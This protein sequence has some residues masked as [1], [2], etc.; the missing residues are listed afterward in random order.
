MAHIKMKL[1]IENFI[2]LVFIVILIS[3][4]RTVVILWSHVNVYSMSNFAI[5]SYCGCHFVAKTLQLCFQ[6]RSTAFDSSSTL[7]RFNNTSIFS[8]IIVLIPHNGI[9]HH[10]RGHALHSK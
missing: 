2:N 6:D 7:K 3:L 8:T 4:V 1:F 9:T 5:I 10:V